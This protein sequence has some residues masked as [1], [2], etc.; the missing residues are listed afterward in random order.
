[1]RYVNYSLIMLLKQFFFKQIGS[2]LLLLCLPPSASFL[3]HVASGGPELCLA[4][5]FTIPM[6]QALYPKLQ[7]C[8]ESKVNSF[9]PKKIN[10]SSPLYLQYQFSLLE[11][12]KSNILMLKKPHLYDGVEGNTH[13]PE[14]AV[15]THCL[16]QFLACGCLLPVG[17][18]E[19]QVPCHHGREA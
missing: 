9:M 7:L 4:K 2:R 6:P 10:D 5:L 18:R 13:V 8:S 17:G 3:L 19:V 16:K 11:K 15:F 12:K 1:M 14:K